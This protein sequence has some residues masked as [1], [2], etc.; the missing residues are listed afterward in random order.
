[1]K[2]LLALVAGACV[3][4][5]TAAL[6][7]D[8]PPTA[9]DFVEDFRS[10]ERT[11]ATWQPLSG[12]WTPGD[13]IYFGTPFGRT[14]LTIVRS[15]AVEEPYAVRTRM[16]MH[17]HG[18]A[19]GNLA[20]V[21]FQFD[22]PLNYYEVVLEPSTTGAAARLRQVRNGVE[23]TLHSGFM[24]EDPRWTW[25]DLEVV[26]T[27][28][29]VYVWVNGRLLLS[30]AVTVPA[31]GGV[32]LVI[33]ST[34]ANFRN[35]AVSRPFGDQPFNST[36]GSGSSLG[37]SPASG[38]WSVVRGTYQNAA[39]GATS[40]SHAPIVNAGFGLLDYTLRARMLNPATGSANLV[41]M[42]FAQSGPGDYYEL[43]FSPTGIARINRVAGGSSQ[44]VATA[45]YDGQQ[46]AWFD[47]QLF[48]RAAGDGSVDVSVDGVSVFENVP[49]AP[50]NPASLASRAGVITH[51]TPGTFDNVSFTYGQFTPFLEQFSDSLPD[52]WVRSGAWDTVGGTLNS[53][54]GGRNDIVTMKCCDRTNFV[55]RAR[56]RNEYGNS[57]NL[58]GLVYNYQPAGQV[59]AGDYYEVVFSPTGV[60][61]MNKFIAGR[62]YPVHSTTH[63]QNVAADEWFKVALIRVGA[64]TTIKVN[65]VVVV[66]GLYQDQLGPGE[67]GV[68][69]HWSQASFD[70]VSVTERIDR[71][72]PFAFGF[73]FE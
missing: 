23:T 37:W 16:L 2:F 20:G 3:A 10:P 7:A 29:R 45:A 46:N 68:I 47:V 8:I 15:L 40:M 1:M 56:L 11:A 67:V 14:A 59:G 28:G 43:V 72:M 27:A 5:G 22:D 52:D 66:D 25:A 44:T 38:S 61:Q 48:V 39:A 32:G 26:R 17:G 13:G 73:R 33:H 4:L 58:I 18:D 53:T 35:F 9:Y 31:T 21:V 12:A 49:L 64:W 65:D 54:A 63:N 62:K 57:G 50:Q 42:F 41:G 60:V 71:S 55:V 19:P 24:A 70:N 6:A 36:F 69:T 34:S 30:P 51:L